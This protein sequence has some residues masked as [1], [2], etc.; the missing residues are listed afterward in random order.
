MRY[1]SFYPFAHQPAPHNGQ[2]YFQANTFQPPMQQNSLQT[3]MGQQLDP[4]SNAL[5]GQ[6]RQQ[7]PSKLENY[8]QT[9]DRFLTTAQQFAPIVQQFAPMVSN[10]PA[11]W[12]LYKGMQSIPNQPSSGGASAGNP[13]S[14]PTPNRPTTPVQSAARGPSMPRV[15]QPP[16]PY[17]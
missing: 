16:N 1:Q 17:L 8:M 10:L 2:Q 3:N 12:R 11:M 9:A 13:R 7:G 5:P 6:N 14:A 4:F 15:F